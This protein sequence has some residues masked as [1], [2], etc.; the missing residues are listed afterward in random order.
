[1]KTKIIY[2][3][4]AIT[5]TA[6][7]HAQNFA[8]VLQQIE[9]NSTALKALRSV[10]EADKAKARIGLAPDNPQVTLNYLWGT[11]AD[12]GNRFDLEVVQE[13][14]FP[15]MYYYRKKIAHG[16]T[17]QAHLDY[18]VQ[19]RKVLLRA[20][21]LCNNLVY[22]NALKAEFDR[23][24]N[25][26]LEMQQAY[27]RKFDNGECGI[28]ELNKAKLNLL[29]ARKANEQNG[30]EINLLQDELTCMNG[31]IP[32]AVSDSMF[33]DI[34]LPVDFD[35]WYKA[36]VQQYPEWQ[37][38]QNEIAL[39]RYEVQLDKNQWLPKLSVGYLSERI[40]GT[41]LQGIGT[42]FSIPLWQNA[43]SVRAAKALATAQVER[44]KD[45]EMQLRTTML[46][47][48]NRVKQLQVLV[49]DYR[50]VLQTINSSELLQ[51]ALDE[52]HITLI[53]YM[54]ELTIYYEAINNCLSAERD[55]HQAYLSMQTFD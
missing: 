55:L 43:G 23:R 41:T 31:G 52:G 2:L 29:N 42:G 26:A 30:L 16:R 48:Y 5:I 32:I 46:A 37:S 3:L 11:P 6:A 54:M 40:L 45:L 33:T 28:L 24:Y 47:Q 51:T 12:I 17:T 38:L 8:S 35:T 15:T 44:Q 36:Y 22:H 7:I 13:F 10:S 19:R 1:M 18:A 34:L 4:F 20:T 27:Q 14:D 21:E 49:S 50:K 53:E 25:R 9:Q 39:A